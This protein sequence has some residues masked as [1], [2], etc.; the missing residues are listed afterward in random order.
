VRRENPERALHAVLDNSPIPLSFKENFGSETEG[1][2]PYFNATSWMGFGDVPGLRNPFVE[3]FS[4]VEGVVTVLGFT[5]GEDMLFH[6]PERVPEKM[7]DS[8]IAHEKDV[9][10]SGT[11]EPEHIQ[12]IVVRIP[13]KYI[14]EDELS[15][16]EYDLYDQ[17]KLPFIFRGVLFTT[18]WDTS[19]EVS[20]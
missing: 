10:V 20:H 1:S 13:A 4:H 12:F 3:G 7:T 8:T 9:S 14:H 11:I 6:A 15:D 19:D 5:P 2:D 16:A 18:K 17:G